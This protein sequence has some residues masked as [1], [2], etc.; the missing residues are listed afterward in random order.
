MALA[1]TAEGALC[2]VA[3]RG[4]PGPAGALKLG[5]QVCAELRGA[6]SKAR[7]LGYQLVSRQILVPI[8]L[9]PFSAL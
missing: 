5:S 2:L 6:C 3:V 1:I 4:K 9:L 7:L 8:P